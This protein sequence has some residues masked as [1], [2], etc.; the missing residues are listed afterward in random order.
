MEF[1]RQL[2]VDRLKA[3]YKHQDLPFSL[4]IFNTLSSTNQTLWQLMRQGEKP[5]C[6][7]IATQQTADRKSV[8]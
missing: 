5:G 2:L 1:N 8:V 3:E 4:H 6:V 7:V